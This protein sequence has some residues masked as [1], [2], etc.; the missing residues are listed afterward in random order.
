M[1]ST[2]PTELVATILNF[3]K[4]VEDTLGITR[5]HALDLASVSIL[6]L[7]LAVSSLSFRNHETLAFGKA[8]IDDSNLICLSCTAMLSSGLERN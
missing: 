5:L 7:S 3:P 8:S 6:T 1:C 2:E 4:W